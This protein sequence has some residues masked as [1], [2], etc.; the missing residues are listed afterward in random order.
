M[1]DLFEHADTRMNAAIN[2][3]AAAIADT[4]LTKKTLFARMADVFGTG[5]ADG[6]WSQ[7]DAYDLLEAGL[8]KHLASTH[9]SPALSDIGPIGEL[10]KRLP[11]HTVR[12]EDQI[13]YQ[14]FSTPADLAALA[15]ILAQ[16]RSSDIVLEPSAGHGSLVAM[17]P[18]VAELHCNELD[19]KRRSKLEILFP[20]ATI[21]GFDGAMLTALTDPALRPTLILMNPPFSRSQGRGVDQLAAVR[22]L[23]SALAKLAPGGR[24]VAIMPDWF[25]TRAKLGRMYDETFA[26]CTVQTSY[27]LERCYHKQGTSVSVR[28]L[29]IDKVPGTIRPSVIAR[30]TVQE[31]ADCV[32][33]VKRSAITGEGTKPM[34]RSAPKPTSLFRAMRAKPK[35][36][37]KPTRKPVTQQVIEVGYGTLETPRALGEQSGVYV[38]YRPSRIDIAG[39]KEH[40]TPLVESVAMGSIPAP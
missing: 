14:Q 35:A 18:A 4:T 1:T 13:R 19:P 38:P 22:H 10:V 25:T 36:H 7:R 39:A 30:Q 20:N 28:L 9:C 3:I 15:V 27:R 40:P 37:P 2:D 33:P 29:V 23:R 11:T 26:N 16:P 17:L 21:T 31:L 34:I 12:S 5:S 6:A 32:R 8:A 24:C